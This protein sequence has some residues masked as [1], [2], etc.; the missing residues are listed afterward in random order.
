MAK[1]SAA[2]C[3]CSKKAKRV[4]K[5]GGGWHGKDVFFSFLRRE[6]SELQRGMMD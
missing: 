4:W 6:V 2:K 3:M 5:G 1:K